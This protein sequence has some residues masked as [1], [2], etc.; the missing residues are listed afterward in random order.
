MRY[1]LDDVSDAVGDVRALVETIG[2]EVRE[3]RVARRAG[4]QALPA[5]LDELAVRL[6]RQDAIAAKHH[7]EDQ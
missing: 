7:S 3:D 4:D 5:R 1:D 6:D 2:A